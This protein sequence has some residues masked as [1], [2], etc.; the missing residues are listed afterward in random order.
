MI[1]RKERKERKLSCE[2][3]IQG[4]FFPRHL[5]PHQGNDRGKYSLQPPHCQDFSAYDVNTYQRSLQMPP[6]KSDY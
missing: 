5:R 3:N 4:F 1:Q 2:I 6:A